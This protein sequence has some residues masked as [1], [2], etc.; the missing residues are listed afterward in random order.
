MSTLA[1]GETGQELPVRDKASMGRHQSYY[2]RP[3][4]Q[5]RGMATATYR[6]RFFPQIPDNAAELQCWPD[7]SFPRYKLIFC[8]RGKSP[9]LSHVAPLPILTGRI[10]ASG[11]EVAAREGA[12]RR[13]TESHF[14]RRSTARSSLRR[15][16]P[17]GGC[18]LLSR[19]SSIA[20]WS[21]DLE[22]H[23]QGRCE[24]EWTS[25]VCSC[26]RKAPV[27]SRLLL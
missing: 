5:E 20:M 7:R 25:Y 24:S 13:S 2:T 3:K 22:A 11:R 21:P 12:T 15:R 8:V 6:F 23:C 17:H 10:P 16:A 19:I 27:A 9:P 26:I 14:P 1:V 4:L 18:L